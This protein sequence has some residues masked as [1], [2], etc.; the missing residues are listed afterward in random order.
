VAD[1]LEVRIADE[2]FREISQLRQERRKQFHWLMGFQFF[3]WLTIWGTLLVF[4]FRQ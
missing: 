1:T 3:S 2:L 4:L